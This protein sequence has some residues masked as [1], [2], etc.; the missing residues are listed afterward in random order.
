MSNPHFKILKPFFYLMT[1]FRPWLV[2]II[3]STEKGWLVA[4][5]KDLKNNGLENKGL[6]NIEN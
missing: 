1:M 4:V 3:K 5:Y 2:V 6:G